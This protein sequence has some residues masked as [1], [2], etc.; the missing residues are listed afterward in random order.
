LARALQLVFEDK[1]TVNGN[2]TIIFD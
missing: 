2:K 1:V